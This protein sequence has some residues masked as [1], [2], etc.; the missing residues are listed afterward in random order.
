VKRL[1]L[2]SWGGRLKNSQASVKGKLG[3][4][5]AHQDFSLG[6]GRAPGRRSPTSLSRELG[7]SQSSLSRRLRERATVGPNGKGM[8]QRRD[9][10]WSAEEKVAAVLNFEKL[11]EERRGAFLREK[12]LH[13]ATLLRWGAIG[14]HTLGRL[15]PAREETGA[16][17]VPLGVF[18]RKGGVV[19]SW[20]LSLAF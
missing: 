3:T 16:G 1:G 14:A 6:T 19:C 10:E 5:G 20:V 12:G 9:E 18:R 4:L 15:L 8:G 2:H 11:A 7:I 17:F 13:E